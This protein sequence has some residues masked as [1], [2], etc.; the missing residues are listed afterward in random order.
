MVL[1]LEETDVPEK[2]RHLPVRALNGIGESMEARL[3]KYGIRSMDALYAQTADQ[4]HGVGRCGRR[5]VLSQAARRR[6]A[7]C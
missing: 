1:V 4:L 2:I 3:D 5:A 6:G 7:R